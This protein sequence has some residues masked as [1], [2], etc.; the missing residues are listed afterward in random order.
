MRNPEGSTLWSRRRGNK[1]QREEK[2]QIALPPNKVANTGASAASD[3]EPSPGAILSASSTRPCCTFVSS[4]AKATKEEANRDVRLTTST[5]LRSSSTAGTCCTFVTSPTRPSALDKA[6]GPDR[7]AT[8][9]GVRGDGGAGAG[10]PVTGAGAHMV[11]S[12]TFSCGARKEFCFDHC[13]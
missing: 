5:A 2:P 4:P 3:R 7:G 9:A 12:V 10:S 13:H 6:S 1:R 8:L 11:V